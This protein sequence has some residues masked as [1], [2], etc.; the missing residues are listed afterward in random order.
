MNIFTDGMPDCVIIEGKKYPV[1]VGFK[2]WVAAEHIASAQS[3][4]CE[5]TLKALFLCY[6]KRLPP[7]VSLAF[8][9]IWD[10]YSGA[11]KNAGSGKEDEIR[12]DTPKN[13]TKLFDFYYDSRYIYCDFLSFYGIDLMRENIHF[14]KF[15]A[16]FEGLSDSCKMTQIMRIRATDLSEIKNSQLKRKYA[17]LKKVY[18]LSKYMP[19][20]VK[21]REFGDALGIFF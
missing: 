3:S 4:R 1:N 21:R 10:F 13:H 16:L 15:C 12:R 6:K 11:F 17:A 18:S 20:H 19:E 9:G 5:D 7:K 8:H 14:Y 2:N